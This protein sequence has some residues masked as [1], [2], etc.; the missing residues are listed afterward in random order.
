M[1][2]HPKTATIA[3]APGMLLINIAGVST[4]ALEQSAFEIMCEGHPHETF[5][6]Y[7]ARFVAY[8]QKINPSLTRKDIER[9]LRDTENT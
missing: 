8:C 4:A 2:P 7:P 1:N 6:A 9:I 5:A 3:R